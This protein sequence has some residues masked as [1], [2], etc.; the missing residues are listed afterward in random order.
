MQMTRSKL[1]LY[2]S[3]VQFLFTSAATGDM[4]LAE[5]DAPTC[6]NACHEELRV[7]IESCGEHRN[8][9]ECEADCRKVD[10]EC[11]HHCKVSQER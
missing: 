7:C 1:F 9:I 3:I 8:P 11:N 5:G 6:R 4:P 2:I 10:Y